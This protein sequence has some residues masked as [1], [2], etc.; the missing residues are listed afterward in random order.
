M[1]ACLQVL[2]RV[3]GVLQAQ[4]IA[5]AA[6]TGVKVEASREET[7]RVQGMD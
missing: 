6:A 3:T 1:L 7:V 2:G 5:V 4:E